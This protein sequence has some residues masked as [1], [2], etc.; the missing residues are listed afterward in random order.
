MGT[1]NDFHM[2]AKLSGKR[3]SWYRPKGLCHCVPV[4]DV[5]KNKYQGL[6]GGSGSDVFRRFFLCIPT[7]ANGA[8]LQLCADRARKWFEKR[9]HAECTAFVCLSV[10]GNE[11]R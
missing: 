2:P 8:G 5:G 3:P 10:F 7:V 9:V 11:K 4:L 1:V 6:G